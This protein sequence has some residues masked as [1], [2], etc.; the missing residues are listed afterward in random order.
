MEAMFD[1]LLGRIRESDNGSGGGNAPAIIEVNDVTAI[2][3][4][5]LD[6]LKAGDIVVENDTTNNKKTA[7][8]VSVVTGGNAKSVILSS[9]ADGDIV[10]VLYEYGKLG[11]EYRKTTDTLVYLDDITNMDGDTINAL[12]AGDTVVECTGNQRHTYIVAYKDDVAGEM[13]LVYTDHEN[14]EE[15]YYE[16][17]ISTGWSMVDRSITHILQTAADV[18]QLITYVGVSSVPEF[19]TSTYYSVGTYVRHNGSVWRF[20]EAHQIGEWIGNDAVETSVFNELASFVSADKENVYINVSSSDG[21]LT[22][23]GLQVSVYFEDTQQTQLLTCDANGDCSISIDKGR[24]FTLSVG[25][26]AGYYHPAS[27]KMR[28]NVN[29]RYVFFV[30]ETT[31]SGY[32]DITVNMTKLGGRVDESPDFNGKT[33]DLIL[34]DNGGARSATI[35]NG[36]AVFEDVPKGYNA[37]IYAPT[38]TGWRKPAAAAVNTNFNEVS[39]TMTYEFIT[40]TGI[41][42]VRDDGQEFTYE[43]WDTQDT[44]VALHV[45]TQDLME[46]GCDYYVK[47]D[48][49]TSVVTIQSWQTPDD[50]R[51]PNVALYDANNPNYDGK[52]MTNYMISDSA[53]IDNSSPLAEACVAKSFTLNGNTTY[54][55]LGTRDQV[56]VILSNLS[57]LSS[58]YNL[59]G[60][61]LDT[62]KFSTSTQGNYSSYVG[63]VTHMY[64]NGIWYVQINSYGRKKASGSTY[65]HR[66]LPFF[67]F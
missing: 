13:S 59:I 55:Y 15:V 6:T 28:A 33:V 53:S 23:E 63:V 39:V 60:K 19:N 49:L 12:K 14:V 52:S 20:T 25:N 56:Q 11:W 37:T 9:M 48:D 46:V 17:A 57:Y 40:A 45:A 3:S 10:N 50:T 22:V 43:T 31:N 67:T 51:L 62:S 58:I 36:V 42:M 64:S 7:Y 5:A 66:I 61:T 34:S 65:Y 32:C 8:A 16:L 27:Y 2:A 24:V 18:A 21:L 4:E 1:K 44:C 47:I 30:Y 29:A 26:Q 54:G 38:I 35:A 41:F